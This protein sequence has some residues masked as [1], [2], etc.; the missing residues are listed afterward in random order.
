MAN[1]EEYKRGSNASASALL[2]EFTCIREVV[3]ACENVL[4]QVLK[5]DNAEYK[6]RV[7]QD[8]LNIL[9]TLDGQL[10]ICEGIADN[11]WAKVHRME[12]EQYHLSGKDKDND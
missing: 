11:V 9:L 2:L 7:I 1:L 12:E 6:W 4:L 5:D 10:S 3:G 8:A